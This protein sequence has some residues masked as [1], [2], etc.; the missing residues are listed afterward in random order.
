MLKIRYNV[1]MQVGA[2]LTAVIAV[3]APLALAVF[4][5]A[6]PPKASETNAL[7]GLAVGC[8]LCILA[9]IYVI[10]EVRGGYATFSNDAIEQYS[11]WFGRTIIPWNEIE[12]VST[13]HNGLIIV[14]GSKRRRMR[15]PVYWTD[16]VVMK[17]RLLDR[18][19][20]KFRKRYW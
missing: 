1:L 20:P 5:W 18:V 12:E 17:Q 3:V 13:Y 8:V 15:F 9:A 16:Y 2:F 10:R 6:R 7:I 11:P 14:K 19:G 4:V